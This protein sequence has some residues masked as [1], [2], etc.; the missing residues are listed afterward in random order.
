MFE[1]KFTP[2]LPHAGRLV[3]TMSTSCFVNLHFFS[4][5]DFRS[6]SAR[7]A[8]EGVWVYAWAISFSFIFWV[9]WILFFWVPLGG[10]FFFF[11]KI[12]YCPLWVPIYY[13]L[14]VCLPQAWVNRL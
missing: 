12:H 4:R 6:G 2:S 13:T 11:F 9:Y 14:Y 10:A 8:G 7:S 1:F 5:Y 3:S